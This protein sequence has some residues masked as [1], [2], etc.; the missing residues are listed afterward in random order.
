MDQKKDLKNVSHIKGFEILY[1][2]NN[3]YN[4]TSNKPGK[5]H[6]KLLLALLT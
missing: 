5:K 3:L 2:K 4:F 1:V 6:M